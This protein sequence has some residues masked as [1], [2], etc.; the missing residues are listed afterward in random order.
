MVVLARYDVSCTSTGSE[1][2]QPQQDRV[3][4]VRALRSRRL[5]QLLA[6]QRCELLPANSLAGTFT[7]RTNLAMLLLSTQPGKLHC[8][9][10]A[11]NDAESSVA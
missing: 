10:N 3:T 6:E 7:R 11:A 1:H 9:W 4:A 2:K 8:L 5:E